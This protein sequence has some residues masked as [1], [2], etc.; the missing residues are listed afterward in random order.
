MAVKSAFCPTIR[1][2]VT[3]PLAAVLVAYG[4]LR[5]RALSETLPTL[6]APGLA[7]RLTND[8]YVIPRYLLLVVWPAK[9]TVWHEV[10]P[11]LR[12]LL[13][14]LLTG[15]GVL[16]TVFLAAWHFGDKPVNNTVS[17]AGAIVGHHL[18]ERL[19]PRI[20]GLHIFN[21]HVQLHCCPIRRSRTR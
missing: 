16:A 20:D 19:G 6:A 18:R 8:L 10:P 9:L 21:Q 17:A 4:V 1:Y 12:R 13:P 11:D 5:T 15:W 7:A 3:T 2:A 14:A